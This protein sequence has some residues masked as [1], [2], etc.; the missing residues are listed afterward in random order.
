MKKP[1]VTGH[2]GVKASAASVLQARKNR[3]ALRFPVFAGSTALGTATVTAKVA[4]G[5]PVTSLVIGTIAGTVA[6]VSTAVHVMRGK[7]VKRA[8][9]EIGAAL[10][11]AAVR[12]QKLHAELKAYKY[13]YVDRKGRIILTN[14]NRVFGIGR[15]RLET[16]KILAK[17]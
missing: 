6:A 10:R 1:L 16:E 13:A 14:K 5:R 7:E 17:S 9:Q 2:P 4:T 12:D 15:M 11:I 8:T 3:G